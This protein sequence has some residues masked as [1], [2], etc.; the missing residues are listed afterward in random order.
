MRE[1][2]PP[3]SDIPRILVIQPII[4]EYAEEH[5]IIEHI[6]RRV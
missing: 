2:A 3:K 5:I 1:L 6:D 4:V